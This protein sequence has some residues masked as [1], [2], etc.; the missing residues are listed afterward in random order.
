MFTSFRL[1]G[2]AR[3]SVNKRSEEEEGRTALTFSRQVTITD[4][5]NQ[6]TSTAARRGDV[7]VIHV[8]VIA[9]FKMIC[10][11]LRRVDYVIVYNESTAVVILKRHFCSYTK[12]RH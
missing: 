10:K 11:F 4:P 3:Q 7:Q 9:Y 2:E 6:T 8:A 5:T 12:E 1:E